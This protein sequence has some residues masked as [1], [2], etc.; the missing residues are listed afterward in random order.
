[1]FLELNIFCLRISST[2]FFILYYLY[3]QES[4]FHFLCS[5]SISVY[6]KWYI[7]VSTSLL[8]FSVFSDLV[9][10]LL[11]PQSE[12]YKKYPPYFCPFVED[13]VSSNLKSYKVSFFEKILLGFWTRRAQNGPKMM[14]FKFFEKLT[15]NFCD[16]LH[17]V[18]RT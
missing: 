14:L 8:H 10:P 16:F 6:K 18:T 3:N 7:F 9:P 17:E 11:D 13:G 1:M 2:I 15:Q 5:N 12:G 4:I